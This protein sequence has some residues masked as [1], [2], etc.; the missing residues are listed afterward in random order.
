MENIL[1]RLQQMLPVID[2]HIE[3]TLHRIMDQNTGFDVHV[4]VLVV[5]VRLEGD[6]HAVPPVRV[7]VTKPVAANLD[8]A[9]GHDV[10][11]LVEVDVVL[12]GVVKGAQ[13]AHR[14][15][16]V[17]AHLFGHRLEGLKEHL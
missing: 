10:R 3:L 12:V 11:L 9:L 5:P 17:D 2:L 4:V 14:G 15:K 8:D 13:G 16:L 6:R 1:H 7:N